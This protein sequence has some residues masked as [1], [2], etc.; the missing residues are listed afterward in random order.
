[1]VDHAVATTKD[2][3]SPVLERLAT[4]GWEFDFLQAVWL[5]ERLDDGAS[6]VGGREPAAGETIRFRPDVSLGFPATD[7][8]RVAVRRGAGGGDRYHL[9]VTFMGLY[10]VSTPLPLHYAIGIL[11]SVDPYTPL[12]APAAEPQPAG[13]G[14]RT[15]TDSNPVRD[16]LDLLHHRLV[17]L[18]YRGMV[19]Y[20]YDLTFGLPDR[21]V[22]TDYLLWL[23]GHSPEANARVVGVDPIRMIR[24]AGILT[25]HPRSAAT[26][27]GMLSDYWDGLPVDVESFVGRWVA[28]GAADLNRIGRL[29]SSLGA[30][31]TVGEQVYD[32][33]GAFRVRVGPVDWATYLAFLPDGA[34]HARTRSLV[35]LYAADPLS[36]SVEV[37]LHANQVPPARL[38]SDEAAGRLGYTSWV[39]TEEVRATSV[40]FDESSL[41]PMRVEEQ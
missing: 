8:R 24:Y 39:R 30:D 33:S 12:P 5:L 20:R 6:R 11:R 17:S 34:A 16:F 35:R 41:R 4:R 29:N 26:L 38:A 13:P 31:L 3:G 32:L 37:R 25:Q 28:L 36:F 22:I 40:I 9:D 21:G 23:T 19:K 27:E 18:F 10:G 1:M 15:A 14:A 2:R 7:V